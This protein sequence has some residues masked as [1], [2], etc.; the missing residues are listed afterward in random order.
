MFEGLLYNLLMR[1]LG[2]FIEGIDKDNINFG[3]WSGNLTLETLT[4]K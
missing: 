1:F 2:D 3:I 4:L